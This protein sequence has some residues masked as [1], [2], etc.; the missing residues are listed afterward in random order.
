MDFVRDNPGEPVSEETFT[1]R[2]P[3]TESIKSQNMPIT[4]K[5]NPNITVIIIN[6]SLMH[7]YHQLINFFGK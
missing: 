5:N 4:G 7:I 2:N 6:L 1:H 3:A